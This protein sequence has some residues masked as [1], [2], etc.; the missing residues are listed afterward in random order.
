MDLDD[1]KKTMD[2]LDFVAAHKMHMY[3][4]FVMAGENL[5]VSYNFI[6]DGKHG[7]LSCHFGARGSDPNKYPIRE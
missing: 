4:C 3:V 6:Y 2:V 1:I 5:S 7:Y